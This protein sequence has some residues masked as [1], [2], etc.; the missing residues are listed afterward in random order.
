MSAS[1]AISAVPERPAVMGRYKPDW[2]EKPTG[3]DM[4]WAY[5]AYAQRHGIEGKAVIKC[6]VGP[7]GRLGNCQVISEI[8]KGE[9]FGVAAV[10][11]SQKFRM[12]P[13]PADYAAK[14]PEVT[15]PIVFQMPQDSWSRLK[16][17][18]AALPKGTE[19]SLAPLDSGDMLL[20]A[21]VGA[22]A[23]A[24]LALVFSVAGKRGR[25]L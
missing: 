14:T 16:T 7:D 1:E 23:F 22:I 13:P 18:T 2:L 10:A 5:P 25:D 19:P 15:I 6:Q 24:L 11:L 20:I 21:G 8:P 4:E 17:A 12:L 3:D 9:D